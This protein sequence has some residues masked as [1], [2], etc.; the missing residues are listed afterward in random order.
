MQSRQ[1][2]MDALN[3]AS[4]FDS[5]NQVD[6]M[7]S[8]RL[9]LES[10]YMREKTA[11]QTNRI[12][13]QVAGESLEMLDKTIVA[14]SQTVPLMTALPDE[15]LGNAITSGRN[16]DVEKIASIHLN[17]EQLNPLWET[18]VKQRAEVSERFH[19]A[20]ATVAELS[21]GL[22]AKEQLLQEMGDRIFLARQGAKLVDARVDRFNRINEKLFND[23]ANRKE[24]IFDT[25]WQ[26]TMAQ[27]EVDSLK[28]AVVKSREGI[29]TL[30]KSYEAAAAKLEVLELRKKAVTQR[31]DLLIQKLQES[32]VAIRE[33]VSDVSIASKAV[34][35]T[36]HY[37]PPRILL[38]AI[39]TI[40]TA[41]LLLGGMSRKRYRQ[42]M[43]E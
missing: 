14:T 3:R 21:K 25:G 33:E 8:E 12:Q 13:V 30:R 19:E 23:Y 34:A 26:I 28:D 37:F 1:A 5:V 32:M 18:L 6:L 39:M 4:I 11:F 35:P 22:Q 2:L 20:Q 31:A 24:E 42:L 29:E 41:V 38:L 7:T 36:R 17:K 10:E 16:S 43:A 40:L 27:D 15:V 9:R